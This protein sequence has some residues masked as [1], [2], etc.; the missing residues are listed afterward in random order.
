MGPLDGSGSLRAVSSDP[1]QPAGNSVRAISHRFDGSSATRTAGSSAGRGRLPQLLGMALR[2]K[3]RAL[4]QRLNATTQAC[5][6]AHTGG[7]L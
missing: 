1:R 3:C 7:H 4:M 5:S 6:I 2:G